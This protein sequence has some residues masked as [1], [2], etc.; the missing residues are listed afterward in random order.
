MFSTSQGGHDQGISWF[1]LQWILG[2]FVVDFAKFLVGLGHV[3]LGWERF[4]GRGLAGDSHEIRLGFRGTRGGL[5]G[6]S[7]GT[8]LHLGGLALKIGI[9][10]PRFRG[11]RSRP[12][13]AFIILKRVSRVEVCNFGSQLG[14][15]GAGGWDGLATSLLEIYGPFR[16]C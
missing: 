9:K 11:T 14:T 10:S 15:W 4:L 6:D 3:G 7:R 1:Q 12:L 5:A 13:W 16:M 2:M 8:R